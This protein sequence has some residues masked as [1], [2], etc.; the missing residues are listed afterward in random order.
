MDCDPDFTD[1][2]NSYA[3]VSYIPGRLGDFITALRE[4]LVM[5]CVAKSHVTILPPRPLHVDPRIAREQ[6]RSGLAPFTAFELDMP[7]IRVFEQTAVVFC[8][9]G[10]G[11]EELF[12]LHAALNTDGLYFD[13]PFDYHPHVTLAQGIHPD[14]LPEVYEHAVARWKESAPPSL[15]TIETVTFV[16]NTAGNIWIDLEECE[17]RGLAMLPVR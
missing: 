7:R 13:E 15:V 2:I 11:R 5:G 9:I 16:Q 4:D 10:R 3:L 17:L 1:P 14:T 6:F 12:D 8:E